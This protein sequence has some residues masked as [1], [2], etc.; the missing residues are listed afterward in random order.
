MY[1]RKGGE[2]FVNLVVAII[3]SRIIFQHFLIT[4]EQI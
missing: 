4:R 1:L 3:S 2:L